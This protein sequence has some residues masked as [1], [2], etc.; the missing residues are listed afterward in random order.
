MDRDA[1]THYCETTIPMEDDY[2]YNFRSRHPYLIVF[3]GQNS[4]KRYV[5]RQGTTTLGRSS[6]ADITLNDERISRIHCAVKWKGKKIIIED[7]ESTNGT[8]VDSKKVNRARL[9]R[10][11]PL[12]VGHSVMKI[13]FK[14]EDEVRLED[15]LIQNASIDFLTGVFNRQFFM[16]RADEEIAYARRHKKIVGFIM[17]DIDH[18][19]QVNDT[20]G[21]Q[22]GDSVLN[23]FATIV[24]NV[25]RTEDV[26][27]RYG[28]EEFIIMPRGGIHQ[29]GIHR[30]CERIRKAVEKFKFH[31]GEEQVR[32]TVSFGYYLKEADSTVEL[33]LTD[34]ISEADKALYLAKERGRNRTETV[35]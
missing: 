14:N 29:K 2:S 5:I 30:Q 23:Q 27:A 3:V 20:F 4:G 26:F 33:S 1:L 10:G 34:L 32:I 12:Q 24:N 6:K 15:N 17:M 21:H 11:A 16:R 22:M 18:F 7:R 25:K 8:Y 19:K 31:F 35:F 13:E 9:R 28:G